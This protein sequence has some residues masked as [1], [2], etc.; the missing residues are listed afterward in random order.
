[1]GD[2][3][4]RDVF[5]VCQPDHDVQHFLNG[6]GVQCTGGLI[7]QDDL[8]LCT[9]GPRNGDALLLAAGE[10]GRI[11]IRLIPQADYLKI[12]IC[13]LLRLGLCF[14]VELHGGQRQVLEHGHVRVEVELLEHHADVLPHDAG[15]VFVGKLLP[16]DI[17]MAAGRLLQKIHAADG[18]RFAAARGSDDDQLL[19]L[20]HFQVHVFQ[21]VQ[22]PEVFIHMF[23]FDH[24]VFRLSLSSFCLCTCTT[25]QCAR[26]VVF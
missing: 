17:N 8:G 10:L 14:V 12:M 16:V 11:N 26:G 5:L 19:A 18:G 25:D 23:Q 4:H 15:L 2:D 7:E 9:E 20:S 6:L 1:M 3:H 22:V 21:N 24:E 13:K